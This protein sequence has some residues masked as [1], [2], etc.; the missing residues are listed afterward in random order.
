MN[1]RYVIAATLILCA[2]Y[3]VIVILLAPHTSMLWTNLAFVLIQAFIFTVASFGMREDGPEGLFKTYPMAL[4]PAV[5][6]VTQMAVGFVF[7]FLF[8]A[9]SGIQVVVGVALLALSVIGLLAARGGVRHAVDVEGRVESDCSCMRDIGLRLRR[10]QARGNYDPELAPLIEA[11]VDK[12]RFCDIRSTPEAEMLDKAIDERVKQLDESG[13]S[14]ARQLEE[15]G[16][17][18][19]ERAYVL[20]ESK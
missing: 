16:R 8:S 3:A 6:L 1:K 19:D 9:A 18:F 11:V 17:L 4:V 10:I 14:D 2:S 7:T 13:V 5:C 12:S 15:L 20:K